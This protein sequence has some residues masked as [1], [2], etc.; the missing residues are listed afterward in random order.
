MTSFIASSASYFDY[1]H[2]LCLTNTSWSVA[3]LARE[4]CPL[5]CRGHSRTLGRLPRVLFIFLGN[6]VVS[7]LVYIWSLE[8]RGN[9]IPVHENARMV[10]EEPVDIFKRPICGFRVEEIR[11]GNKRGADDGPDNPKLVSQVLNSRRRNLGNHVV[12]NPVCCHG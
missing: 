12:A 1:I 8:L 7:F 6:F 2:L 11:R 9:L 4:A 10:G 3:T 5:R